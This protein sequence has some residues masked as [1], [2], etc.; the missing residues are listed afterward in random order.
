MVNSIKVLINIF[1]KREVYGTIVTIAISYFTYHSIKIILDANIDKGKDPYERKKRKTLTKFIESILGYIFTVIVIV[2]I[3][4]LFGINVKGM[5]AG[6]GVIATIVGLALQDTFKDIISGINIMLEDYF[7]VGDIVTY[8]TFAGSVVEFDLRTTKIKDASGQ[9]LTVANRNIM[10]I[11]NISKKEQTTY[12]RI[13]LPYEEQVAKLEK[14]IT[15]QILP[16]MREVEN[17]IPTSVDYLGIDEMAESCV[18]YL[19]QFSCKRETQWKA[20]REINKIILTTLNQNKVSKPYSQL[21]VHYD[22]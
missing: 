15:K 2:I 13:C 11:K 19:V 14:I 4:G 22:K 18:K 7:V 5:L 10:E 20:K 9:I 16:K 1:T 8:G 17:V 3:L 21:E 6:L 12:I